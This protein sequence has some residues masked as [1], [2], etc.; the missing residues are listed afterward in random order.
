MF[1]EKQKWGKQKAE[2]ERPVVCC[3]DFWPVERRLNGGNP[4]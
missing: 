1:R 4:D 2:I 3:T